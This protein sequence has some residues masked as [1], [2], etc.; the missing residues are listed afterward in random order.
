MQ[1]MTITSVMSGIHSRAKGLVFCQGMIIGSVVWELVVM[2][3]HSALEVGTVYSRSILSSIPK[4]LN[5][6]LQVWS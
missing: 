4:W 5:A 3:L 6:D 1:V 2:V